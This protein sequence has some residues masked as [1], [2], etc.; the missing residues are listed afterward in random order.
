M[1]LSLQQ[2]TEIIALWS[3][4]THSLY[5]FF[6][7]EEEKDRNQLELPSVGN[8]FPFM[9]PNQEFESTF[10]RFKDL[11]QK[12]AFL[13]QLSINQTFNIFLV[14]LFKHKFRILLTKEEKMNF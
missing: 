7:F 6:F 8:A 2:N 11:Y 12:A 4:Y 5:A 3:F 13:K 9:T 14:F 10:A 1:C